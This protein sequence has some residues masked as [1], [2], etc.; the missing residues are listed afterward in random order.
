MKYYFQI[1]AQK[2][3]SKEFLAPNLRNFYFCAKVC[4][5]TNLRAVISIMTI[6]F[7][8]TSAK[9]TQSDIFGFKFKKFY[10]CTKYKF[11]VV[12]FKYDNNFF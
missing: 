5:K 3:P 7:S 11:E 12:D 1:P 6:V 4:N 8:T 10:F 9:T 2:Y